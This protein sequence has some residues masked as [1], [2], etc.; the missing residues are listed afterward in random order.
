MPYLRVNELGKRFINEEMANN[1]T[2][3][4][5]AAVRNNPNRPST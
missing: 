3:M 2:A 1:H 4:S 5:S